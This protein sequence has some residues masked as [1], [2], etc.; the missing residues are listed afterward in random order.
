MVVDGVDVP[1]DVGT[2]MT[3]WPRFPTAVP[4]RAGRAPDGVTERPLP[5]QANASS[6][7]TFAA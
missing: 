1:C 7:R 4:D 6:R 2:T 3:W 5:R